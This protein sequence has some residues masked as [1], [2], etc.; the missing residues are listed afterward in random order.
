[1]SWI[2][3]ETTTPDKAEICQIARLCKCSRAEAFLAFFRFY[4][5]LDSHSENGHVEFLE[6]EDVD[7]HSGLTG[8][9]RAI[10]SV[11]W[12]AFS[13]GFAVVTNFDKH[14]GQSS[15]RRALEARRKANTR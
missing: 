10:E 5:W 6:P 8:F 13:D 11:K 2:K 15:K 14:N 7:T 1:M 9:G 12:I 3:V 4:V